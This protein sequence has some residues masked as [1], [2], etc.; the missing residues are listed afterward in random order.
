MKVLKIRYEVFNFAGA[1]AVLP[2]TE[3][4][5]GTVDF[6]LCQICRI[7]QGGNIV[8][9]PPQQDYWDPEDL[10]NRIKNETL[11]IA[12]GWFIDNL[13]R[14][15]GQN[16]LYYM[17]SFGA[18]QRQDLLNN[19][20]NNN[21][22]GVLHGLNNAE[23]ILTAVY[24]EQYQPHVVTTADNG[25]QYPFLFDRPMQDPNTTLDFQ[26]HVLY[27]R[28]TAQ[29]TRITIGQ[30][31]EWRFEQPQDA[32]PTS[33]FRAILPDTSIEFT[34]CVQRGITLQNQVNHSN[35]ALA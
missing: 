28:Q 13:F 8:L 9:N 32:A 5:E 12:N 15:E 11:T 30:G 22:G 29:G 19:V 21:S 4:P 26:V 10:E 18:G 16:C 24:T 35:W 17:E 20:N 14:E 23:N 3:P 1:L 6:A 27:R 7:S 34:A 31:F 33:S 25:Q 2:E